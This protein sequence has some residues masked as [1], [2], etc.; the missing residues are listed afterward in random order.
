MLSRGVPNSSEMDEKGQ[1]APQFS[2]AHAVMRLCRLPETVGRDCDADAD[3]EAPLS[4]C[5]YLARIAWHLGTFHVRSPRL[6]SMRSASPAASTPKSAAR[7]IAIDHGHWSRLGSGLYLAAR[8]V[9]ATSSRAT[10]RRCVAARRGRVWWRSRRNVDPHQLKSR[11]N[12][13]HQRAGF[14][15]AGRETSLTGRRPCERPDNHGRY[16]AGLRIMIAHV[17]IGVRDVD[18]S[19]AFYD[20]VLAPLGYKCTRAARS[21]VGY[22]YGADSIS[23]WVVSA[24]RP[25]ST[26]RKIGAAFLLCSA[27]C[28]CRRRVSRRGAA[29]GRA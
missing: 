28:R 3:R 23:F 1:S 19:R 17:S 6:A 12:G 26:R 14:T 21:L 5:D 15:W 18:R 16:H 24:E 13:P 11:N 20:A 10:K 27:G 9:A 29:R 22:G 8:H 4:H 25:V 2:S 7:P